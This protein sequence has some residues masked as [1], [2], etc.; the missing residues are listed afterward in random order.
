MLSGPQVALGYWR[1]PEGTAAAFGQAGHGA[2]AR[3]TY[4]TGDR[5]R[6][7]DGRLYF[8]RRGDQQVKV[9]G[10]RVELGAIDAA[11][12]AEGALAACTVLIDGELH[13]FLQAAGAPPDLSALRVALAERLAVHEVPKVFH[14]VESLPLSANDKIDSG[15]LI[16][17]YRKGAIVEEAAAH[18]SD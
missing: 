9:G 3:R 6:R 5:G 13:A 12:R 7:I 15:A 16:A 17:A 1:D 8:L 18:G 14:L 4:R 10:H 2:Q 11:L